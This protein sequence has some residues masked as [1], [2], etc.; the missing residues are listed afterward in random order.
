MPP[1]VTNKK[2]S[3][4][5]EKVEKVTSSAKLPNY[6]PKKLGKKKNKTTDKTVR[7]TDHFDI[8]DGRVRMFRYVRSGDIW[9]MQFVG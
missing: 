5:T 1:I 9:K 2:R 4:S 8:L 3:K 7:R 6:A